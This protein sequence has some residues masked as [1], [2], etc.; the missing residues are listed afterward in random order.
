MPL[1]IY[2]YTVGIGR[3]WCRKTFSG[4]FSTTIWQSTLK[5]LERITQ[6]LDMFNSS[7][8][9]RNWRF[10]FID[11][12]PWH[13][14]LPHAHQL[15]FLTKQLTMSLPHPRNFMFLTLHQ[16]SH[17]WR[18][19]VPRTDHAAMLHLPNYVTKGSFLFQLDWIP[20]NLQH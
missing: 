5:D 2:W 10:K 20:T 4:K 16:Q 3:K 13:T 11:L 6:L 1:L 8:L 18:Q 12:M 7:L 14:H 9:F 15:L 19:G 17:H